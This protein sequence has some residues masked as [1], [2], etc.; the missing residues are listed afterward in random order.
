[1]IVTDSRFQLNAD[2]IANVAEGKIDIVYTAKLLN[3]SLRTVERY[4]N[5]KL[6]K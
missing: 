6:S 1:M 4:L 3:K 5:P 2:I